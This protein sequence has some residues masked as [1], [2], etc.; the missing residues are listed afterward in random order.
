MF[1][2]VLVANRGEI[3]VRVMKTLRRMGIRAVTVYTDADADTRQVREADTAIRIPNY[4][5]I[6]DMVR[7]ATDAGA[8][9]VHPG[10][11]F[12]AENA[13]FARACAD[14]GLVFIGPPAEAID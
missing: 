14:A 5:S 3:A 11:G 12:L 8:Q 6:P 4:L 13:R 2:T 7:A 10:Y 9:A 1:D